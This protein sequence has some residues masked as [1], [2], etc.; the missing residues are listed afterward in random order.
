MPL[1]NGEPFK[2]DAI[3]AI[4]LVGNV[5]R[6]IAAEYERQE[7]QS[8]PSHAD[9]WRDSLLNALQSLATLPE[10]CAV[11][12]EDRLYRPAKSGPALRQLL[13]PRRRGQAW[14]ILFTVHDADADDPP[15]VRVHHIRHS[16]QQP[17]AAWPP[18]DPDGA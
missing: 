13:H 4:R 12:D 17:L 11:A 15:T 1:D 7:I 5:A 3:Y 16:A 6:T 18:E 8:G 2:G 9:R 14:R 10:R